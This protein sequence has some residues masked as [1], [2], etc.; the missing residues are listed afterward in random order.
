MLKI[1]IVFN[2]WP[3]M[4]GAGSAYCLTSRCGLGQRGVYWGTFPLFLGKYAFSELVYN[5]PTQQLGTR[6]T[7][8]SVC[9]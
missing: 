8:T 2:T 6:L 5:K 3:K 7:R 1:F 9:A 4:S